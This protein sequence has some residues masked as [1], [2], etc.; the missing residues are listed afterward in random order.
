MTVMGSQSLDHANLTE[1]EETLLK[2]IVEKGVKQLKPSIGLKGVIYNELSEYV[3]ES[4]VNWPT[5]RILLESLSKKGFLMVDEKYFA[6]FCPA[7]DSAEIISKYICPRCKSGEVNRVRLVEHTFC[8]YTGVMEEFASGT[9]LICPNCK[10]NL[11]PR[12]GKPPGDKSKEDYK[13][14]GTSFECEDCGNRFDRPNVGHTCKNC[15]EDFTYKTG[16][17]SKYFAFEVPERVIN[18]FKSGGGIQILLV[19]DAPDDAAIMIKTMSSAGK[20]YNVDHADTG[21][22]A[23]ERIR[24]NH[25]DI[26]LLDYNLP[27]MNGLDILKNIKNQK[28]ETPVMMFTGADD[29]ET[30]VSAM[31]LGAEDYL[32]KTLDLYKKLP[33]IIEKIVNN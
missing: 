31:K 3:E 16:I 22:K 1:D 32:I 9:Q 27:G 4:E 6:L 14:I 30:A 2:R 8:G 17:Y 10:T 20:N 19:E 18:A 15:D 24:S 13:I 7:C 25:Y 23:L 11:G 21:T 33:E 28:I 12:R 5:V 26:I 29:R